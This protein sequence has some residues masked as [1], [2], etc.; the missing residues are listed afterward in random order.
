MIPTRRRGAS[1][2]SEIAEVAVPLPPRINAQHHLLV[3]RRPYLDLLLTGRKRIEC[4]L[5][6]MRRP[7]Y[8]CVR[9]GEVLWLKQPSGPIRGLA[10]AGRCEYHALDGCGRDLAEIAARHRDAIRAE[11]GFFVDAAGWAR[12]VS[13]IWIDRI[14]AIA[15]L[16]I[17]KRDQRA[18]VV[19]A[20]PP[21]PGMPIES[22]PS[23]Q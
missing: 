4:R 3:V 14:A 23:G 16:T 17:V 2:P 12:Y 19:L 5:S 11:D 13:L 15:P 18:W 22:L 7:P 8:E 20:A 21:M 10:V 6:T 1:Q 9:S